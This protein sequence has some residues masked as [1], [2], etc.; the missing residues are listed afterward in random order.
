M[1]LYWFRATC[2]GSRCNTVWAVASE[3]G[4]P[5]PEPKDPIVCPTCGCV[6]VL[7]YRIVDPSTVDYGIFPIH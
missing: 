4:L 5:D 3:R 6:G 2:T 1:S 7:S